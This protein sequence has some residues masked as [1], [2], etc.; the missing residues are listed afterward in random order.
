[1]SCGRIM[2]ASKQKSI[3]NTIHNSLLKNNYNEYANRFE[4]YEFVIKMYKKRELLHKYYNN[5]E[6]D[7]SF[8]K[9]YDWKCRATEMEN[10]LKELI[11]KH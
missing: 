9:E 7:N 11:G 8:F 3:T 1:M 4:F 2:L 10:T 6:S 5:L